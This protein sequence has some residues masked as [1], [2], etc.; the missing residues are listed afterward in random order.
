[1]HGRFD[2]L[3]DN[4]AN[5]Q[6][7][8]SKFRLD[9]ESINMSVD[10]I[11]QKLEPHEVN[12]TEPINSSCPNGFMNISRCCYYFSHDHNTGGIRFNWKKAQNYCKDMGKMLRMTVNLAEVGTGST[13]P[14]GQKLM[15]AITSRG[16]YTW[17][18]A[19]DITTERTWVWEQTR[20]TLEVSS[21]LWAENYPDGHQ[22]A[23]CLAAGMWGYYRRAYLDDKPCTDTN[24]FVCQIF[25]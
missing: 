12:V 21:S 3:A 24:F 8:L 25:D 13:C 20:E 18:G 4:Y 22:A 1:M 14:N 15:G 17:L 19:T 11:N 5:I 9:L 7:N 6:A 2:D 10:H 16:K 23:N